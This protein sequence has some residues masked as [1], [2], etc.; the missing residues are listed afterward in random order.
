[1]EM[2]GIRLAVVLYFVVIR[3]HVIVNRDRNRRSGVPVM[4]NEPRVSWRRTYD[5]TRLA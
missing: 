4:S 5:V 1:M 2:E 3:V